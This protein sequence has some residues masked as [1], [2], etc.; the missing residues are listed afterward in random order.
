[1]NIQGSYFL[2]F[3][4]CIWKI[5]E[6]GYVRSISNV[7]IIL[8]DCITFPIRGLPVSSIDR[9]KALGRKNA[10]I[11]KCVLSGP[12]QV[13]L[14]ITNAKKT[15]FKSRTCPCD[16]SPDLNGVFLYIKE[17]GGVLLS[18]IASHAVPSAQKSLTS[19]FGM[20]TGGTSSL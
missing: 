16:V 6:Q 5:C 9:R 14:L 18:H 11:L 7:S 20:G 1:M 3:P 12:P 19:V 17:I 10:H 15:P 4:V 13:L 2:F 8:Q